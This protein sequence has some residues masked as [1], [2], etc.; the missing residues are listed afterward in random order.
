MDEY[1]LIGCV[2]DLMNNNNVRQ[3]SAKER[4]IAKAIT[5]EI[6]KEEVLRS[7]IYEK[8]AKRSASGIIE[9]ILEEVFRDDIN[10]GRIISAYGY[11]VYAV[12]YNVAGK[13]EVLDKFNDFYKRRLKPWLDS[14]DVWNKV[15]IDTYHGKCQIL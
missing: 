3:Y 8:L 15:Y 10:L 1:K 11:I 7:N 4:R 6:R 12:V 13:M 5:T 9:N 14:N 2:I